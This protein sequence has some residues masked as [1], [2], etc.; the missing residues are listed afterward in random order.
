MKILYVEDKRIES[1]VRRRW[2]KL[3]LEML[4]DEARL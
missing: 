1:L 2:G 3:T 4:T